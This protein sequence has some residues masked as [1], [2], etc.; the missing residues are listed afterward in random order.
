MLALW[1]AVIR[2]SSVVLVYYGLHG[3]R[4]RGILMIL[5]MEAFNSSM[6]TSECRKRTIHSHV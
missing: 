1:I 3:I 5:S 6:G 4:A 2:I